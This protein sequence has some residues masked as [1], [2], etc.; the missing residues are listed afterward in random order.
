MSDVVRFTISVERELLDAF[1][2]FVAEGQFATRSEAIR[3]LIHGALTRQTCATAT[4]EASGILTLV[5]DHHRTQVQQK[6][7]QIQHDHMDCVLATLHVHLDHN[8]CME[9]IALRGKPDQLQYIAS[10]LQGIKGITQGE[11]VL[12]AADHY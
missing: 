5:Y 3:Q 10:S 8:L 7:V 1:D 12:A 9:A 6:L 11:L 2:Q 4:G